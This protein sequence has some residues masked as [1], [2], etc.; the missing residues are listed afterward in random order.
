[1]INTN[2]TLNCFGPQMPLSQTL[3][4]LEYLRTGSYSVHLRKLNSFFSVLTLMLWCGVSVSLTWRRVKDTD[5][6]SSGLSQT[7]FSTPTM[8]TL[9]TIHY[10][11][12]SNCSQPVVHHF[13]TRSMT[14]E[15]KQ[16]QSLTVMW[17]KRCFFI[18][19]YSRSLSSRFVW[20]FR[21]CADVYTGALKPWLMLLW[22]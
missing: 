5:S 16:T 13:K 11:W 1:M 6:R 10:C 20:L 3:D 14:T 8:L 17:P 21:E 22:D 15:E 7:I 9:L 4:T 18:S 12:N 2:F 19:V